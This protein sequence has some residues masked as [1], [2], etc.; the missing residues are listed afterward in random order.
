VKPGWPIAEP[1]GA[2]YGS[3][4]VGPDGSAYIEECGGREVGCVLHRLGADGRE[5]PGWP[6]QVPPAS[7]CL[8]SDPCVSYL[9]I[10]SEGTVY[11]VTW[12][13]TRGQQQIIAIDGAGKV[14]AGWP[15]ALDDEYGWWSYPQVGSDGTLFMEITPSEA[16]DAFRLW[17]LA[18]DGSPRPGW[19]L[20]VPT[21]GRFQLGPEGTVVV[22]SYEP[23]VDPSQGG[24]CGNAS[25]TV[26][27][28]LGPDGRTLAGWPR[29]S[30]RYASSPVVDPDGTVYYLSAL[31]NVYAHD[32]AGE[33]KAGWPVSVAGVYPGCA[34]YGP[35]LGP[36][37]TIYVLGDEVVA[38]F[39]DGTG[40][41]YRPT[42]GLR[43][44]CSDVDCVPFP[45]APAFGPDGTVY[46]TVL[47]GDSA[48]VV[49]LDRQGNMKPGWPYR[50]P[51]D[52][53]DPQAPLLT[54]SPDGQLYV[55]L[56]DWLLALDPDGRVSD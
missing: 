28:V 48:E 23:L 24:L 51:V 55:A 13:K 8:A 18:P 32:Q 37:G 15:V 7:V 54:S 2:D 47:R 16:E 46:I 38:I 41:R 5:L 52:P 14:R 39:P 45:M 22:V 56:G 44:P 3:L 25:R 21:A 12:A 11:L 19:P 50:T 53:T 36:D 49:A 35:Y 31:G 26:F 27:T 17:A 29:G 43:W 20:S 30:T 4:K 33:V 42:G 10:G 1:P 6:F 40:W 34:F 9:V